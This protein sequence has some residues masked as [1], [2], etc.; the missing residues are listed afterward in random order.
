[1]LIVFCNILCRILLYYFP[2]FIFPLHSCVPE[3]AKKESKKRNILIEHAT[4]RHRRWSGKK[5]GKQALKQ[6]EKNSTY[7]FPYLVSIMKTGLLSI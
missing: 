3:Q 5:K 6:G 1:M 4:K 2:G 7:R